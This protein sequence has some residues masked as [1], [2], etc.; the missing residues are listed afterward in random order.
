MCT[1]EQ[2]WHLL[3]AAASGADGGATDTVDVSD[4]VRGERDGGRRWVEEA[5]GA[6]R[7]REVAGGEG[8]VQKEGGGR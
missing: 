8:R 3:V 6:W 2:R 7:R 4:E 5:T 1:V